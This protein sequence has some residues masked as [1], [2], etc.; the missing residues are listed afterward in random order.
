[1][2]TNNPRYV[3]DTNAI[4]SAVLIKESVAR[5]AFDKA[6]GQGSLLQSLATIDELNNVLRRKKFDHYITQD[7]RLLFLARLL[8]NSILVE[9]TVTLNVCRDPKD[10]KFLELALSG[11]ASHLITGDRDLLSLLP[12][13]EIQIISPSTFLNT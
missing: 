4:V 11:D 3:F 12:F 2:T 9:V 6:I 5:L 10:D 13:C 8:G 1:M 7:E